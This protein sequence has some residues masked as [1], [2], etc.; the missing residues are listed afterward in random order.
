MKINS[1]SVNYLNR[2]T[3]N[4]HQKNNPSNNIKG[5]MLPNKNFVG[6]GDTF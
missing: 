1:I 4:G 3:A 5:Q 2:N 6:G